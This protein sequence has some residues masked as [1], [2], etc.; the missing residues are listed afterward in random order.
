MKPRGAH[1]GTCALAHG[2]RACFVRAHTL[3]VVLC[4]VLC[5]CADI[6]N[7]GAFW[8]FVRYASRA[9]AFSF[10]KSIGNSYP[11]SAV[12]MLFATLTKQSFRRYLTRDGML[13]ASSTMQRRR[14]EEGA[15]EVVQMADR[16]A[17]GSASPL[18]SSPSTA[19]A[20]STDGERRQM[21]DRGRV[22]VLPMAVATLR[23]PLRPL[24]PRTA[25]S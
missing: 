20:R 18:A 9:L 17:E 14:R 15:Q 10:K 7:T 13:Q 2:R 16:R 25:V 11:R 8:E 5:D 1:G 24:L 3:V 6:A 4:C 19:R 12:R 22:T 21:W 23:S